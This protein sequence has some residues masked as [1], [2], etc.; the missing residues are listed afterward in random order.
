MPRLHGSFSLG[1]V[2]GAGLGAWAAAVHLPVLWHFAATAAAVLISVWIAAG[3]YQSERSPAGPALVDT[4]ED[5][6]LGPATG[7]IPIVANP[8]ENPAAKPDGKARIKAAWRDKRTLLLGVLV[9]GLSIAEGAAGDWVALAVFV[10]APNQWV[11]LG[12]LV[13]WGLGSSLG[14]PVGMSAA[15]DDPENAAAR[16]SVVS[17]IGYGAFLCGPPLLGLLAEHVGVLHSLLAV[18]VMLVISFILTP[19]VHAP[20]KGGAVP[21]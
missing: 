4:V 7:P 1:T 8:A 9:L 17:T 11:A 10:F 18:L 3:Y 16:V 13:L 2:L 20:R 6:N 14:F 5:L 19:Y 12:A 21:A 15:S